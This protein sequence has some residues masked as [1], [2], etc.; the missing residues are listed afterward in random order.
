M[1]YEKRG[2]EYRHFF[3]GEVRAVERDHDA[4]TVTLT[5][6]AAVFDK[7]A[8]LGHFRER[9]R[10]GAFA[11][12][13]PDSD[14]RFLVNHEGLPLART[15]SGTMDLVETREGLEMTARLDRNDPDVRALLPKIERGDLTQFSFAF[16]VNADGQEFDGEE[17]TITEFAE[18]F[19]VSLVTFPAFE[20]TKITALRSREIRAA[21]EAMDDVQTTRLRE[22]LL[23]RYW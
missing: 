23:K 9:I 2:I 4:D 12:A 7:W 1:D 17:R 19:D 14:V 8:D 11:K 6:L 21:K 10:P 3:G 22:V 15:T 16:D 18:I 13:L 5:G 20:Q